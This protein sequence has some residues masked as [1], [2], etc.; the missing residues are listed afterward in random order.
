MTP[1]GIR[2]N[3]PGNIEHSDRFLWDGEIYPQTNGE[4]RFCQFESSEMGIRAIHKILQTYQRKHK[5]W[6]VRD[7]INRWAPP[8]ENETDSY[9]E[10]VADC[11]HLDPGEAFDV[12]EMR[13]ALPMV[14]A[15]I[16]HEN[17]VM[18]YSQEQLLDGINRAF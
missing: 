11:M 5:L 6:N 16:H 12:T 7:M 18:P 8:V 10:H 4:E 14:S 1:R 13:Y 17:G 9:I 15:I 2:N 3:N